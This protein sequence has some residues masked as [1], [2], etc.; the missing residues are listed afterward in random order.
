MGTPSVG[1][2]ASVV[3]AR[4][5]GPSRGVVTLPKLNMDG[6]S[7]NEYA[8]DPTALRMAPVLRTR[9]WPRSARRRAEWGGA[10]DE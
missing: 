8:G 1:A 3:P 2:G 5:A 10:P 9:L 6:E 4:R 7:V